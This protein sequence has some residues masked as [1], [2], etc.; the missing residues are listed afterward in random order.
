MVIADPMKIMEGV[1]RGILGDRLFDAY[2]DI[3]QVTAIIVIC[4]VL[5]LLFALLYA[6]S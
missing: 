2:V 5:G 6:C 1:A 3:M 4:F